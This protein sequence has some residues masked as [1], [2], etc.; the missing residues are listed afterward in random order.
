MTVEVGFVG[1]D[2]LVRCT[3]LSRGTGEVAQYMLLPLEDFHSGEY[4]L[5]C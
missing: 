1:T 2:E 4:V 3:L 5:A